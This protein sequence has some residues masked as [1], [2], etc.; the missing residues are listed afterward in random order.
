VQAALAVWRA[1]IEHRTQISQDQVRIELGRVAFF[2]PRRLFDVETGQLLDIPK[3]PAEVR[4][5]ISSVEITHNK[6]GEKVTK[7]RF[8]SKIEALN[9]LCRHLGMYEDK[10]R[11]GGLE[12]ELENMTDDEI[13]RE[14]IELERGDYQRG[15][16]PLLDRLPP[17][18]QYYLPHEGQSIARPF[19]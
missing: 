11:I 10:L 12:R 5:A 18:R 13:E 17:L 16:P 4:A 14:L 2:D 6:D 8:C 15:A 9:K 1:A 3:L 7:V 19:R